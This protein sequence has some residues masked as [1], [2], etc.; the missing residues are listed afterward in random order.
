MKKLL[1]AWGLHSDM[2]YNE[3]LIN[4]FRNGDTK[5]AVKMFEDMP[6]K[7]RLQTLKSA[8][9]GGWDSGLTRQN[10]TM[11]FDTLIK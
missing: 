11:L 2:Q 1:K 4:H 10:L 8:T 6:I 7:N 3:I 9:V 5:S